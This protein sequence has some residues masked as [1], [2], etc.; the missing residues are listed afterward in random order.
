MNNPFRRK[1]KSSSVKPPKPTKSEVRT[2]KA[3]AAQEKAAQTLAAKRTKL[4]RQ[5][6][7]NKARWDA[8]WQASIDRQDFYRDMDLRRVTERSRQGNQRMED[9]DNFRNVDAHIAI[10]DYHDDLMSPLAAL[11]K[12]DAIDR[13]HRRLSQYLT[14]V[15]A[16]K[17]LARVLGLGLL[18]IVGCFFG[19]MAE[20]RSHWTV[21]VF[22]TLFLVGMMLYVGTTYYKYM[23]AFTKV[24]V[25]EQGDFTDSSHV[26]GI[27]YTNLPRLFFLRRP[28]VW[29]GNNGKNGYM[30]GGAFVC[31]STGGM[32][33]EVLNEDDR[34]DEIDCRAIP[35]KMID[36]FRTAEDYIDLKAERAA[37][38][39]ENVIARRNLCRLLDEGG[40][41]DAALDKSAFGEWLGKNWPWLLAAGIFGLGFL[42]LA[43]V[44]G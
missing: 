22:G 39:G 7:A 6:E 35:G 26:T 34:S 2:L 32:D 21:D 42:I 41:A 25:F 16:N 11:S 8:E 33:Y 20:E 23:D 10:N 15:E 17:Y 5:D 38:W 9:A 27:L 1:S 4:T 18:L 14:K 43:M 36:A 31:L 28:E 3:Q 24:C 40:A 19:L 13:H 30:D 44:V 37:V 12:K 29:R